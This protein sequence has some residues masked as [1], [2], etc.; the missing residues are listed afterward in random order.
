MDWRPIEG[1]VLG[2]S[3]VAAAARFL[4]RSQADKYQR[5]CRR[6]GVLQYTHPDDDTLNRHD[7]GDH[8][9]G[10]RPAAPSTCLELERCLSSRSVR[11]RPPESTGRPRRLSGRLGR[12]TSR[13]GPSNRPGSGSEAEV[14]P[15]LEAEPSGAKKKGRTGDPLRSIRLLP[16]GNNPL[17]PV[18]RGYL[19]RGKYVG[20]ES[21]RRRD[22]AEKAA[23][24]PTTAW[25]TASSGSPRA[26]SSGRVAGV[27]GA[28]RLWRAL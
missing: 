4:G 10:R 9:H 15:A 26:T 5:R 1:S 3:L 22:H 12:F 6:Q 20:R 2:V 28:I 7:L 24:A 23:F 11:N 14:G 13:I 21:P 18:G 19:P 17:H 27:G 8:R 25:R 16:A